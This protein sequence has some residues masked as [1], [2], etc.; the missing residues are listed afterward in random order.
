MTQPGYRVI[1]AERLVKD[2]RDLI[3]VEFEVG[4][5]APKDRI[6][7]VFDPQADWVIRS[8]EF[9]SGNASRLRIVTDVEYGP[10]RDD[11]PLPRR[12]ISR[13]G[14]GSSS[15]CEFVDW[16]FEPTPAAEFTMP[17]YGLPDL[18]SKV[19]KRRNKLP[20]WLAGGAVAS[21]L[22]TLVFRRLSARGRP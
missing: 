5:K 22:L 19:E 21:L 20:Y 9:R 3:E 7:I 6:V 10:P 11:V 17:Y 8:S 2:G 12:V 14:S 1:S 4:A 13:D 16:S 18:V 15:V